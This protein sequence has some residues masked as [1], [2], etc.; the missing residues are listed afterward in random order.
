MLGTWESW[1]GVRQAL[2]VHQVARARHLD[3]TCTPGKLHSSGAP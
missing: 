3:S 1:Q 2:P